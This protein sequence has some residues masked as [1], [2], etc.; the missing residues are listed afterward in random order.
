MSA[1]SAGR[2]VLHGLKLS[3]FTGKLEAYLRVKGVPFDYVE[4]DT[5]DFRA[6]ARATGVA[7]MPQLQ[8]PDGTWLT[9]TT[10]I[11]ARF[12]AELPTP[13]LTPSTPRGAFVARLLEDA[14]DEW[15]WRPALYFR[16]AFKEDARLMGRQIARTLL[17]DVPGP[18]WLRAWV[19]RRRQ[20][21]VFL[22]EDGVTSQT[23]A[24]IEQ[25]FVDVTTQL[26]T[27]LSQ[28]PYLFGDRPCIADFGL[29][30][31]FMRHF[32]HDPTPARLMQERAPAVF[33]WAARTW[34]ARASRSGDN[35]IEAGIPTDWQPLLRE[36]GQTHLE[37]LAQNAVAYTADEKHHDLLVQGFT[38]R[39][40]PT[41]AYRPWCLKQLQERFH[42]LPEE[43]AKSVREILEQ[44]GCWEPLW[45]VTGFRCD[46]D[47]GNEA[48]FC[49]ATRMVRD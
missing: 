23:R 48:P 13:A 29:M 12:E 43:A 35:P 27:A 31:P 11:I 39:R 45:R 49:Q 3:Y 17:R 4:M 15:L 46:H 41:S 47:P 32:V 9:D 26:D 2:Y 38:Y 28:R 14:F 34:N 40:V 25:S 18:L 42:S 30:G 19:I 33:E 5:A 21:R 37:A 44:N 6:C 1:P 20:Q 24:A 16:W 7:Q 36:V 22:K 10:A 8:A